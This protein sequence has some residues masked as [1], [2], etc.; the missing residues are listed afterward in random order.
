MI[1]AKNSIFKP[2]YFYDK[3]LNFTEDKNISVDN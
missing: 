3:P 2:L 1:Y